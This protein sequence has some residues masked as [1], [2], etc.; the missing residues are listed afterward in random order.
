[1]A[2]RQLKVD[3]GF[4]VAKHSLQRAHMALSWVAVEASQQADGVC[5]VGSRPQHG[6]H[7]SSHYGGVGVLAVHQERLCGLFCWAVVLRQLGTRREW[8]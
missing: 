6:V 8:E 1:M 2:V 7:D 5:E 3:A 4:Q